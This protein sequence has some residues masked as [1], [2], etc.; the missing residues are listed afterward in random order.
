MLNMFLCA[1]G[2]LY[3]FSEEMSVKAF[4]PFF[5]W[6]FVVVIVVVELYKLFVYFRN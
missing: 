2:H 5:N 3:V 4:C 6:V 1:K